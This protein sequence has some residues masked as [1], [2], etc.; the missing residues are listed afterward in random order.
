MAVRR[1]YFYPLLFLIL[2]GVQSAFYICSNSQYITA[3]TGNIYI[4]LFMQ[5]FAE[6]VKAGQLYPRWS[7]H[8]F[9]GT[10]AP[11]FV[12]YPPL[13][14]MFSNLFRFAPSATCQA[15]LLMGAAL[16]LRALF[17]YLWL[18]RHTSAAI[19]ATIC[20]LLL[21]APYNFTQINIQVAPAQLWATVWFPLA[22]YYL[23]RWRENNDLR[24]LMNFALV[25]ALIM[26]THVP[27]TLL[28]LPALWIYGC[29]YQRPT[30]QIVYALS[31]AII[32]AAGL[33]SIYWLPAALNHYAVQAQSFYSHFLDR[34]T[35]IFFPTASYFT[36]LPV[37]AFALW[38]LWLTRT[39]SANDTLRSVIWA[40]TI[41][42]AV[43][44]LLLLPITER[45]W[46]QVNIMHLLQM[47]FRFLSLLEVLIPLFL[48]FV[49]R[50][51]RPRIWVSIIILLALPDV[52]STY[53]T[54][55]DFRR[56]SEP[57]TRQNMVQEQLKLKNAPREYLPVWATEKVSLDYLINNYVPLPQVQVT[58]GE[59]NV[60][61]TN[62]QNEHILLHAH[63][64]KE[65]SIAI[66]QHFFPGWLAQ[67]G[68]QVLPLHPSDLG[69]IV[70]D[71][72]QGEY[73]IVLQF[74]LPGGDAGVWLT[75][76][77]A[78][79]WILLYLIGMKTGRPLGKT[80]QKESRTR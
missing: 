6:G 37:L 47:P 26:L 72:S 57:Q 66:K 39:V 32:L 58:S 75:V 1:L 4:P 18:R 63:M 36:A 44:C 76:L 41:L 30:L 62:W 7:E 34:N 45:L 55:Q 77:S 42:V 46:H 53:Y 74:I 51:I 10:G 23:E 2:A 3:T 78:G 8:L 28:F 69:L 24:F 59:G 71:A 14:Y 25:A 38:S 49:S 60:T 67:S 9:A 65:G 52:M 64:K 21:L 56:Y 15:G 11:L 61:V 68:N 35:A 20:A 73:D 40:G 80:A 48:L 17:Y 22:F 13:A 54:Y 16:F 12:F 79:L 27:S 5:H 29:F 70:I 19:A 31:A 33:A 50:Y 43:S